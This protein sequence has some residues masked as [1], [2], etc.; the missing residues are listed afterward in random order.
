M[1]PKSL[2]KTLGSPSCNAS[3]DSS[4]PW[5]GLVGVVGATTGSIVEPSST[6]PGGTGGI[7]IPLTNLI[8]SLLPASFTYV[9]I[10]VVGNIE[11][12]SVTGPP[13]LKPCAGASCP[14]S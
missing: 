2:R 11:A 7:A 13:S 6:Y 5:P 1:A 9:L 8:Y 12:A 4:L 3:S 10:I 14:S